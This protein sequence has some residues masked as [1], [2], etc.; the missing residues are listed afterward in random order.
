MPNKFDFA[1]L[2]NIEELSFNKSLRSF[3]EQGLSATIRENIQNAL[4]AG[5][6]NPEPT[7]VTITVD[8]IEQTEIPGMAQLK[9]HIEVLRSGNHYG[10]EAVKHIQNSLKRSII[11]IMTI[12]DENT[13]GLTGA[14]VESKETNGNNTYY[15][16]AYQRGM[17]PEDKNLEHEKTRG[18][19][20]GIG[21]IANNAASDINLMFFANC[22]EQGIQHLGGNIQLIEHTLEN[23]S[24]RSTGYFTIM[25]NGKH[26]P[27]KNT[28]THPHFKKE[29]R[30]LKNIIPFFRNEYYE[31]SN[32]N[33]EII[34]DVIDNFF[35]AILERNLEVKFK[36]KD[37]DLVY[38]NDNTIFDFVKDSKYYPTDIAELKTNFTPLYLQTLKEVESEELI[39]KSI[40]DVYK[41]ELFF[42][43]DERISK[44]R[45]ALLRNIGMKI[46]DFG[47]TGVK[48]RP[49]NGVLIGG[50]KEDNYLKTL[51]N[52]SHTAISKDHINDPN[53]NRNATR[54]INNLNKE[55]RARVMK[56]IER[57]TPTDGAIDTGDLF[58]HA[59]IIFNKGLSE[60]TSKHA[61]STGELRKQ[62][63]EKEK[64]A[65][66]EDK[67]GQQENNN[68]EKPRRSRKPR[69][70]KPSD[71]MDS[72][73]EIY[74]PTDYV[75]R[76]V[77]QNY[78]VIWIDLSWINQSFDFSTCNLKMN[79]IDGIGTE[80]SNQLDF[81]ENFVNVTDYNI[82]KA[83]KF[84]KYIIR[85]I[86]VRDQKVA[87]KI[88]IRETY[89]K[90]LKFS[91]KLE[92]TND[93]R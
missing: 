73:E 49:F 67:G 70:V 82:T 81:T 74:I 45:V 48:S 3:Y 42:N 65:S 43:Y 56:E 4:D 21:K 79:V 76:V 19:S 10:S 9:K 90:T 5:Q 8:Q 71:E 91:Y 86:A 75:N 54:F 51:E 23:Q 83:Y 1:K 17:H 25:R 35:W 80:H 47:A 30:G 93:L 15:A 44:G 33:V 37:E 13:T 12:E 84:D 57:N 88:K 72:T 46:E 59:D 22:D 69:I 6:Q 78:E 36:I 60:N 77:T 31:L 92:V 11:P 63:K 27:F 24:Y 2:T 38:L 87:L 85:D 28:Q 62:I 40:N 58:Y 29:T 34:K 64:R 16:Y 50:L 26:I 52:E 89:N 39:V 66:R 55:I 20:H 7:V 32:L 68:N 53:E 41:F 18:G 14:D 61:L